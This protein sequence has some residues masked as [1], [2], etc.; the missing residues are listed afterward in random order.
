LRAAAASVQSFDD[1]RPDDPASPTGLSDDLRAYGRP[2]L[3][4]ASL[5]PDVIAFYEDTVSFE[6]D[7]RGRW[8]WPFRLAGWVWARLVAPAMGQLGLP[9]PGRRIDGAE[10]HS[11]IVAVNDAIDGRDHVRGW[12]RIW[13][14]SRRTLYVAVYS[15]HVR[16]GVRYMNIA[17]PLPRANLT[18]LLHLMPAGYG[19][20]QLTSRHHENFAGD[21]AYISVVGKPWRLRST[22]PSRFPRAPPLMTSSRSRRGLVARHVMWCGSALREPRVPNSASPLLLTAAEPE[23]PSASQA[24]RD[25]LLSLQ[26][27]L[28]P[29]AIAREVK[30]NRWAAVREP[31]TIGLHAGHVGQ[32]RC[33]ARTSV[34]PL[35]AGWLV[36]SRRR[37]VRVSSCGSDESDLDAGP[38]DGATEDVVEGGVMATRTGAPTAVWRAADGGVVVELPRRP[39]R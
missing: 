34:V 16:D 19:G 9:A 29:L 17:F 15:E 2:G 37:S 28:A 4:V 30:G 11:R 13:R 5:H 33:S 27:L 3:D 8:H 14:R 20:L 38:A 36:A 35:R 6:L 23:H 26:H 21:Q 22:R 1:R 25:R 24:Q 10:L 31:D 12:I 18:S 39:R 32:P 7:L